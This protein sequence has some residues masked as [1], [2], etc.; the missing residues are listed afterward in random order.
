MPAMSPGKGPSA[1]NPN[2]GSTMTI[3]YGMPNACSLASHIW[4][5]ILP[6]DLSRPE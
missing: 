2:E 6:M 4:G 3:L 1:A 5:P